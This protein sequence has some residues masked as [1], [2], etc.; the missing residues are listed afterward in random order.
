MQEIIRQYYDHEHA[1]LVNRITL[2]SITLYNL[3]TALFS[4]FAVM[5]SF[6]HD[7]GVVFPRAR[8][9]QAA[10]CISALRS[11]HSS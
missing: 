8:D 11:A 3:K 1:V 10:D 7:K 9:A 4:Y 2:E 6:G 5:V